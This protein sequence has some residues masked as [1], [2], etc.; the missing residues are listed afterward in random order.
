MPMDHDELSELSEHQLRSLIE[1]MDHRIET[2][3]MQNRSLAK[4]VRR[5]ARILGVDDECPF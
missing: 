3:E 4:Y 2:L 1:S 5:Y